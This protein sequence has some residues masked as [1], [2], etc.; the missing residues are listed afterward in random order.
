[1]VNGLLFSQRFSNQWPLNALYIKQH[2]T[3]TLSLKHTHV[4]TLTALLTV[5][6]DRVRRLTQGHL[7]TLGIEL[8]TFRL[9]VN[10]LCPLSHMTKGLHT[11]ELKH[12]PKHFHPTP[13]L[14]S[15]HLLT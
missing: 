10:P 1:M 11:A 15:K 9:P 5:Q 14:T 6:G 13:V 4:H 2:S 7:D 12:K 3:F 8:A